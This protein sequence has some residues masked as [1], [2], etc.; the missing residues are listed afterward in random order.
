MGQIEK[1]SELEDR[2]MEL[3]AI[4]KNKEKNN[5]KRNEDS[6]ADILDNIQCNNIC[7]IKDPRRR[8]EKG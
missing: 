6:L 1:R 7:I 3:T 8:R 5:V 4:G 2:L